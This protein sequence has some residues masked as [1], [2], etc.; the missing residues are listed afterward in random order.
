MDGFDQNKG[1]IVIGATNFPDVLDDA[2]I[3]PG[4]FDRHVTV[5]LPDVAGRKEILEYYGSKVPLGK[6]VDLFVLARATPDAFEF[7]KDIIP[8]RA[9]RRSAL[10][11]PESAKVTAYHEGGHALVAINTPGAHPVYKATIIPRGQALGMVS[12][13]PEGDQ[14]RFHESK[15]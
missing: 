12:Q 2:L 6:D 1:I 9:E 10:I 3:R 15:C 4:R 13:L 5:D 7:A 11:T 14:R 8:M